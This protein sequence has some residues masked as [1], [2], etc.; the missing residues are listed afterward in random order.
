MGWETRIFF[1]IGDKTVK[2]QLTLRYDA[3]ANVVL[4]DKMSAMDDDAERRR[5]D[6]VLLRKCPEAAKI[7]LKARDVREGQYYTLV[8]LKTVDDSNNK[9]GSKIGGGDPKPLDSPP[10]PPQRDDDA[11]QRWTKSG[12]YI[13]G[14]VSDKTLL[15]EFLRAHSS[16]PLA[17]TA[18]DW[19]EQQ[20]SNPLPVL[21]AE[22]K[23]R[24][25]V[26]NGL[27]VEE[28]DITFCFKDGDDTSTSCKLRS[29]AVEGDKTTCLM[30]LANTWRERFHQALL[31]IRMDPETNEPRMWIASYPAMVEV[32]SEQIL[33]PNIKAK[34]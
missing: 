8:E 25:A 20:M 19:L 16:Q 14:T 17:D 1:E 22:K 10:P 24:R 12:A 33:V 30:E 15:V 3:V 9:N 23:R 26:W 13:H 28:T 31:A 4:P 18:R 2:E 29:W 7:G 6:Y 5:D 32:V 11:I 21:K 34:I 27:D